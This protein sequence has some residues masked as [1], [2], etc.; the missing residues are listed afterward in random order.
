MPAWR[1]PL[2]AAAGAERFQWGNLTVSGEVVLGTLVASKES[3]LALARGWDFA[4]EGHDYTGPS[5]NEVLG[6][7]GL[8]G[9]AESVFALNR[10]DGRPRW[11]YTPAGRVPHNGIAV[12]NGRVYLLDKGRSGGTAGAARR[13]RRGLPPTPGRKTALEVLDLAT[14]KRLWHSRRAGTARRIAAGARRVAGRQHGRYDRL[15]RR[16]RQAALVGRYAPSPC[17]TASAFLRAPVITGD[18][19]YD[20]PYAYALR[21]GARRKD[22]AGQPWQWGGFRGC[23][24][25]SAG[26]EHVVLP[27]RHARLSGRGPRAAGLRR[28]WASARAATST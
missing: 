1:Q 7:I 21:T 16:R 22:A 24:T 3:P 13:R 6:I 27:C 23:G 9:E 14:G 10:D 4:S 8:E 17:T 19:V 20:E 28:S 18:W 12:G 11:I 2:L 25:V 15:R 5:V 26:R